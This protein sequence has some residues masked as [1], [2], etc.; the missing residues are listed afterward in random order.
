MDK[1]GDRADCIELCLVM[2]FE[3]PAP[4]QY[5][6]SRWLGAAPTGHRAHSCVKDPQGPPPIRALGSPTDPKS[7]NWAS[8]RATGPRRNSKRPKSTVVL[9]LDTLRFAPPAMLAASAGWL[10][11]GGSVTSVSELRAPP[12]AQLDATSN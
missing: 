5:L 8:G 9:G 4:S 12:R 10:L 6:M 7:S 3:T 2:R 1:D 11:T